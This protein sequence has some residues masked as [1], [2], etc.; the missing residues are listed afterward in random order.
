[1]DREKTVSVQC[2][3]LIVTK[4]CK[5]RW[6][7]WVSI[8]GGRALHFIET[9]FGRNHFSPPVSMNSQETSN[10]CGIARSTS[11][12]IENTT[13]EIQNSRGITIYK[14][15]VKVSHVQLKWT[16]KKCTMH[17]ESFLDGTNVFLSGFQT[18]SYGDVSE[19]YCLKRKGL[20]FALTLKRQKHCAH[21]Y[22]T[23]GQPRDLRRCFQ[24][25]FRVGQSPF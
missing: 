24:E 7:N 8:S 4:I 17:L 6:H 20:S 19:W 10:K 16:C 14:L 5:C 25:V 3:V 12:N 23:R 15:P 13:Y 21:M 2:S 1:M 18:G 11:Q 22:M 9:A